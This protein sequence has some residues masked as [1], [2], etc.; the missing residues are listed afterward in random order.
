M[1]SI[2]PAETE[3]KLKLAFFG[4]T[5]SGYFVEVGANQPRE[6]SQ[7][8][9]LEQQGWTGLLIEP[10]PGLADELKRQR[11]ARVFA[12]ACSS[13][14]NAGTRMTLHLAGP[15]SSFDKNLNLATVRPHGTIEV[16]VRTLDEILIEASAPRIDFISIDVEGHE[17]EVLDGFNLARWAPRLI[18][19]ED[20]LLHLQ[21]HRYLV[22]NG[23]RWMRRTAINNWYVPADMPIR[24]GLDGRWQFFNKH[25]LGTPFRRLRMAWHRGRST[26]QPVGR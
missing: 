5:N 26:P 11:S 25:Y 21:L 2:F 19:I 18:L 24:L 13:R 15:H 17:L 23:Y 8:F 6:L 22:R 10:Q 14:R 4:G 7:T 16:P 9:D 1:R 12:V 3:S 20:L